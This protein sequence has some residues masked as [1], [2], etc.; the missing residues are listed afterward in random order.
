MRKPIMS[1]LI[2]GI[3]LIAIAGV[4]AWWGQQLARDGL[5]KWKQSKNRNNIFN[6]TFLSNMHFKWPGPLLVLNNSP[7]GKVLSPVSIALFI[8]VVNAKK[9]ISR[10]NS[11]DAKALFRYDEGGHKKLVQTD[12]GE[13]KL[14]YEPSGKTVEKWRNLYSMGYLNDQVYFKT[15]KAFNRVRRLDFSDNNLDALARNTQMKPGESIIGWIFFEIDPDLR[16]QLPDIQKLEIT[17]KNS[18]EEEQTFSTDKFVEAG[19]EKGISYLSGGDW[20]IMEGEY[21]LTK[22]NYIMAAMVDLGLTTKTI[23]PNEEITPPRFEAVEK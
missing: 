15:N 20:K 7:K 3:L 13:T 23:G 2:F 19:S 4:L 16:G 8:E 9:S 14:Q 10:I 12:K 1:D 11:Y 21:D 6:V 18:S 5:S 17:V 22:E